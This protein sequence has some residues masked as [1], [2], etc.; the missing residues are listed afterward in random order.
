M[1]K[2][3]QK[4]RVAITF[5]YLF[6]LGK[7]EQDNAMEVPITQDEFDHLFNGLN[8]LKELNLKDQNVQAEMQTQKIVPI[9][10][11]E[12]FD[13]RYITGTHYKSYSG[14]EIQNVDLGKIKK[15][16]LNLR[17]FFFVL[18]LSNEGRLYIGSQALGNYS[19]YVALRDTI[20][21]LFKNKKNL[22]VVSVNSVGYVTK[23]SVIKEV[24]LPYSKKSENIAGDNT[25][26][27]KG[28]VIFKEGDSGF[29]D[30]I[31][32]S[33]LPFV[34]KERKEIR[35]GIAATV[36]QNTLVTMDDDDLDECKLI[37]MSSN[38]HKS[39]INLLDR[40][41]WPTHFDTGLEPNSVTGHPDYEPL[42][43]VAIRILDDEIIDCS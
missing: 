35:K 37:V 31:K 33:I 4:E 38:G 13:D 27:K 40:S 21:A 32:T 19:G 7:D 2:K 29:S 18:Y 22:K 1:S 36:S 14:H 42:K 9:I 10:K 11:L 26:G 6:R 3:D 17:H 30:Q 23:N 20:K 43:G 5:H 15:D 34:D 12:K 8:S 24:Q 41:G 39:V 28:A 25:F 16:S